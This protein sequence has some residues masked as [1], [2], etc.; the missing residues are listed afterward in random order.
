MAAVFQP[1]ADE[2]VKLDRSLPTHG[3][4]DFFDMIRGQSKSA[5]CVSHSPPLFT[6]AFGQ[7]RGKKAL[8]VLGCEHGNAISA[9]AA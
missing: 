9:H 3:H 5:T 8:S 2:F 7:P 1:T 6:R 4:H